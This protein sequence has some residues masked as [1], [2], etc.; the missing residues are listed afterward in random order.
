M[1]DINLS[2][3]PEALFQQVLARGREQGVVEQAA[4]NDL[5][6]EVIEVHRGAGEI[7]T[8][9]PTEDMEAQLRGRWA[10]YKASLE[11]KPSE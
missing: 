10:D 7:A 2:F 8:G 6:E 9:D 1:T 4:Y 3:T 5:V 11:E